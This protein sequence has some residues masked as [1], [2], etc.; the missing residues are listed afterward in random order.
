LSDSMELM[1]CTGSCA[2]SELLIYLRYL[3]SQLR[4]SVITYNR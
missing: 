3:V 2:C 1:A 4:I